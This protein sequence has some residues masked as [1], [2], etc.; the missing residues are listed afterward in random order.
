M[1]DDLRIG[2]PRFEGLDE[3]QFT[4]KSRPALLDV[5]A[6]QAAQA[7]AES[8]ADLKAL[9]DGDF[10]DENLDEIGSTFFVES[11]DGL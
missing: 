7:A 11:F 10:L 1:P 2:F 6:V 4:I 3:F 8:A 5:E 9:R